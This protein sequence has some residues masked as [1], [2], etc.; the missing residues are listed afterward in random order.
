MIAAHMKK[1]R[2]FAGVRYFNQLQFSI[3]A[4]KFPFNDDLLKYARFLNFLKR[5]SCR[6]SNIEYF[7]KHYKL[8]EVLRTVNDDLY[9]EFT[10]YQ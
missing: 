6:F 4:I 1:K 2:F 7:T 3:I 9:D 5:T 10:S 8:V